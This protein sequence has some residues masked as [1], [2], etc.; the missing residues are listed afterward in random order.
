MT[1]T[2]DAQRL[3]DELRTLS[4]AVPRP[5]TGIVRPR[6]PPVLDHEPKTT[7]LPFEVL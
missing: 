2:A 3:E 5:Q 4:G 6:A 1:W 7:E